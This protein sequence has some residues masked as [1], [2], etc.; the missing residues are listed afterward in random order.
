M[1]AEHQSPTEYTAIYRVKV[2]ELTIIL[3][4]IMI[5]VHNNYCASFKNQHS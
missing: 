3:T 4:Y 1:V 2:K 5:Y